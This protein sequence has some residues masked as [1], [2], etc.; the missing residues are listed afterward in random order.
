MLILSTCLIAAGAL[1]SF[2]ARVSGLVVILIGFC[3]IVAAATLL[4]PALGNTFGLP[5]TLVIAIVALQIGYGAA[6]VLRSV[7]AQRTEQARA[8]IDRSVEG[9]APE[10]IPQR[11]SRSQDGG[12]MSQP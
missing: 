2:L 7:I 5:V 6:I 4:G 3:V 9:N 10:I 11:W 12:P 8:K 1:L